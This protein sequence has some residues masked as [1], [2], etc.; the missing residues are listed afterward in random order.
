[1]FARNAHKDGGRGGCPAGDAHGVVGRVQ[2]GADIVA[3]AAVDAHVLACGRSID[4]H[5]LDRADGVQ[6]RG[7]RTDNRASRLDG[8]DRNR[9]AEPRALP[10]DDVR[11]PRGDLLQRQ[12]DVDARVRD[13]EAAAEIQL[14]DR[15]AL[16]QARVQLE[17]PVRRLGEPVCSEDLGADVGVQAEE[18]EAPL[19][20]DC[21][22]G[23][24][25]IREGDTELLILPR[26]GQV[27][28]GVREHPAVDAQPHRLHDAV[29]GGR[30]GDPLDL[31]D[32]VDDQH[33]DTGTDSPVDLCERL[34][35][36]V[37]AEAVWRDT[38]RERDGEFASAADIDVEAGLGDPAGDL[39]AEER[40]ARVVH[41]GGGS[42][43]GELSGEGI[44]GEA[45]AVADIRL[46]HRVDGG[47][48]LPRNLDRAHSGDL[49]DA[50]CRPHR[51]LRPHRC[52][53]RVGIPGHGEP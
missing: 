6:R 32:A 35:V 42:D 53:E 18:S 17:Q 3:H 13:A 8:D 1:M 30:L 26:G 15:A 46:I 48:E 38:G 23:I 28:V 20:A 43:A 40:L 24:R 2:R 7:G 4:H 37:E 29:T 21:R 10:R 22:H 39:G 9:D 19:R 14:G 31:D 41:L 47:A 44:M 52:G 11:E 45:G 36:A 16:Q 51:V 33:P 12:C 34:V 5:V 49:Q 27:F 25:G 50:G